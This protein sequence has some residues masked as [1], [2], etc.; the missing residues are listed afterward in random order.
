MDNSRE[1]HVIDFLIY[2]PVAGKVYVQKRSSDRRLFPGC[3][4]IPGGHLEDGETHEEC[5][6]RELDEEMG[7]RLIKIHGKVHEFKWED[8]DVTDHVYLIEAEGVYRPEV[9]KI[10]EHRWIG[11]DESALVLNG[12]EENGLYRAILN[13]FQFVKEQGIPHQFNQRNTFLQTPEFAGFLNELGDIAREIALKYFRQDLQLEDK[14]DKT[15]VT[16]ADREIEAALRARIHEEFPEHGFLGEEFGAENVQAEFVWVIDPIDG[17]KAFATGKPLFGTVIGLTQN[18]IPVAGMIDQAFT[19]ERWIGIKN[20]GAT[21]NGEPI[22]VAEP[23]LLMNA[24]FYTAAP[25]MF[26][27]D[28]WEGFEDIRRS[29]KWALYGCD[30]YAYGLMAMGHVDLVMEQHLGAHDIMG[31]VPIIQ[32]AGGFV[33]DWNGEPI[34]LNTDGKII[35]ASHPGLAVEALRK[36]NAHIPDARFRFNG[37]NES[38]S[39]ALN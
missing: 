28:R 20:S 35:A 4:E 14:D 3:W 37:L 16:I 11:P 19:K 24:R 39:L 30:C 9:D 18:S 25:E 7:F 31:L 2:D 22:R 23:R 10:S 32:E 1:T 33:S 5:I 29:A 8:G 13:A 38:V 15:P 17:T 26:H 27:G 6:D 12:A 34:T 21:H 36:I